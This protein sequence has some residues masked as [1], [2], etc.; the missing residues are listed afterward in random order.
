MADKDIKVTLTGDAK[1]LLSTLD[2]ASSRIKGF[3]NDVQGVG[4]GLSGM[5]GKIQAPLMALTALVGGGALFK[6]AIDGT[7]A[8]VSEV[9]VLSKTLGITSQEASGLATA[10]QDLGVGS[11]VYAKAS[12]K[13]AKDMGSGGTALKRLG[14]EYKDA[15]GNLLPLQTVMM[16]SITRLKE[17]KEGSD[18]TAGGTIL[19]GKS[20]QEVAG[21][22]KISAERLAE[23]AAKAEALHK[24]VG[25][26]A[27]K[28]VRDY[29]EAMRDVGDG[30]EA[31]KYA[32]GIELIP[33]LTTLANYL[34]RTGPAAAE[35]MAFALKGVSTWF[36]LFKA[37]VEIGAT[38][39]RVA[40]LSVW[41]VLKTVAEAV[42]KF[43]TMDFKG[44]WDTLKKGWTELK[45]DVTT[46]AVDIKEIVTETI[47]D[48]KGVWGPVESKGKPETKKGSEG[49]DLGDEKG[50]HPE[51]VYEA[52]RLKLHQELV[53]IQ[54]DETIQAKA[55]AQLAEIQAKLESEILRFKKEAK[56][57][58]LTSGDQAKLE[59]QAA[60]LAAA[61]SSAVL[62]KLAEDEAKEKA[63]LDQVAIE[64]FQD[65]QLALIDIERNM[66]ASKAQLGE[67]SAAEEIDRLEE[68]END[69]FNIQRQSLVRRLA[70]EKLEP[71][72]RAKIMADIAKV[73]DQRTASKMDFG[74]Q[75]KG[76]RQ[77]GSPMAG[78]KAYV[79]QGKA[80]LQN[81]KN[82]AM[83]AMQGVE[84]AFSRGIEGIL[85]GQ[86]SLGEG[87]KS[88]WQGIVSTIIQQ[89]AQLAAK[90]IV[91][92]IAAQM[93]EDTTAETAENVAV[94]Q[95]EA[96]AASLWAAYAAIPF[97]GPAL[98]AGFIAMMNASLLANA[99]AAKGIVAH[100]QGGIIDRPTLALMGE[101]PGSREIVAPES[102]FKDWAGNLTR[103]ILASERQ[104]QSYSKYSS[105]ISRVSQ[106][107]ASA[108]SGTP[109][110]N[111]AGA[112][113]ITTSQREWEDMVAK[114]T[115]GYDRRTA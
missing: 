13:L 16:N 89:L 26:D 51:N 107:Q 81:W 101:L 28:Q 109:V 60:Q 6:S 84:N 66:I 24:V 78:I 96:A 71:A 54:A 1:G 112:T 88:I 56:E 20:W 106:R 65:H 58:K 15:H 108:G 53:K 69:K 37:Y 17:L 45:N 59:V 12:V 77:Q 52:E 29:K 115:R 21:I 39:I 11:D 35:G 99:G 79:N 55:R 63:K 72:E 110:H 7:V 8:W 47:G 62:R 30:A 82:T 98:A 18:R 14:I 5:I 3:A 90:W 22:L 34:G 41:D 43:H 87:L 38:A 113:I 70:L 50:K 44:A 85:S 111:Y 73:E 86:M 2:Q 104:A 92:S 76:L 48:V 25:P 23:G 27:V 9:T 10:L 67:I 91:T 68:L 57:G 64:R 31:V 74:Q 40:L 33:T 83:Q 75:R 102:T 114:G 97:A 93:F 94:A 95:Q 32:V 49:D 42:Y 103:N 61:Q 19:F 36:M 46:G 100:A 4:S 105:N 80:E